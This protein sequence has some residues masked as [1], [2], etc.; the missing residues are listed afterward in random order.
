M[1]Q[2][3]L[4][5]LISSQ[6]SLNEAQ[7]QSL[8]ELLAKGTQARNRD[9][10]WRRIFMLPLSL[11]SNWGIYSRVLIDEKGVSYCA[12]QDYPSE[13]RTVRKLVLEG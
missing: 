2:M 12:G 8:F 7:K 11:W 1:S 3:T 13:I 4:E 10:L 9:K 6:G 5:K